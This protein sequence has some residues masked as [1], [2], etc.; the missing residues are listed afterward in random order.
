MCRRSAARPVQNAK[1][2]EASRRTNM[3]SMNNAEAAGH[4][5]RPLCWDLLPDIYT[6]PP[7]GTPIVKNSLKYQS[8]ACISRRRST[9]R[10]SMGVIPEMIVPARASF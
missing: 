4:S 5:S 9:K 10:N 8:T 2:V 3:S 1:T 6:C 7:V